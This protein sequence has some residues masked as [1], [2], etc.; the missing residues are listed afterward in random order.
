MLCQLQMRGNGGHCLQK[1]WIRLLETVLLADINGINVQ[2]E[3][4]AKLPGCWGAGAHVHSPQAG[5]KAP[6]EPQ[7]PRQSESDLCVELPHLMDLWL[8]SPLPEDQ[9]T[10]PE[11]VGSTYPSGC[12]LFQWRP[13]TVFIQIPQSH[14]EGLIW[15][16]SVH[17]SDLPSSPSPLLRT[18]P[19]T[20]H[21]TLLSAYGPVSSIRLW[22]PPG[23]AATHLVCI[24]G[25]NTW[26]DAVN[27]LLILG[28]LGWNFIC[29]LFLDTDKCSPRNIY[30]PDTYLFFCLT[31][32]HQ[33]LA[34]TFSVTGEK[35]EWLGFGHGLRTSWLPSSCSF[36]LAPLTRRTSQGFGQ[37][38][39][40]AQDRG[41]K[42][43]SRA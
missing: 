19:M 35:P 10:V 42:N 41:I 36:C 8:L 43:N 17:Q 12:I 31:S 11:S 22:L 28:N 21:P 14:W 16:C 29:L 34:K 5:G 37:G 39:P 40:R 27:L 2:W 6:W 9:T 15:P 7:I 13:T 26:P 1:D 23:Q 25:P 24:W 20:Y 38:I 33:Q 18:Q 32:A 3:E 4:I 30:V